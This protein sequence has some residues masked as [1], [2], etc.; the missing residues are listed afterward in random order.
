MPNDLLLFLLQHCRNRQENSICNSTFWR[1]ATTKHFGVQAH[2]S[3][4]SSPTEEMPQQLQLND[5]IIEDDLLFL[6]LSNNE[7]FVQRATLAIKNAPSVLASVQWRETFALNVIT[8]LDFF[9]RVTVCQQQSGVLEMHNPSQKNA[10]VLMEHLVRVYAEPTHGLRDHLLDTQLQV[11]MNYRI[12]HGADMNSFAPSYPKIYFAV[13]DFHDH[14]DKIM[15]L[16]GQLLC[17]ELCHC[18]SSQST[19]LLNGINQPYE[20][21]TSRT[22]SSNT[23]G[24][25]KS[26]VVI[27]QGAVSYE[28]VSQT[29]DLK[30][31]RIKKTQTSPRLVDIWPW[32][33]ASADV[34]DGLMISMRGPDGLKEAQLF[35]TSKDL[36][37]QMSASRRSWLQMQL[38]AWSKKPS[39]EENLCIEKSS[40]SCQIASVAMDWTL[41]LDALHDT[42]SR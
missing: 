32:S 13:H 10:T 7:I 16:P 36:A 23:D 6:V 40:I 18:T 1:E 4:M 8:R 30:M 5:A 11:S 41:I 17:V 34:T 31:D 9:L 27:F 25:S 26:M 22:S 35:A 39:E 2:R 24:S 19:D 15:L 29:I 33:Q 21:W 20:P 37:A 3:T 38:D 42:L 12:R 14:V 28:S